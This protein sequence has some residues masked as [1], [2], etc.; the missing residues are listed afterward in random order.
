MKASVEAS[1]AS[2]EASIASMNAS[3]E[4]MEASMEAPPGSFHGIFRESFHGIFR[5]S[6]H[7]SYH[8]S[9]RFHEAST[10]AFTK[11]ST[12]ASTE[13]LPRIR[14]VPRKHFHGFLGFS[15]MEASGSFHGRLEAQR[16][17]RKL[18]RNLFVKAFDVVSTKGWKLHPRNFTVYL[19]GSFRSFHGISA[20]STTAPTDIFALYTTLPSVEPTTCSTTWLTLTLCT[21]RR[22]F[23]RTLV[24]CCVSLG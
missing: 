2:M 23:H 12:K 8:G 14:K 5:E 13:V 19:H 1:T 24:G 7:G 3:M 17:P 4:D 18:P 10:K 9:Y 20:A 6:F 16:L 15:S 22:G 21:R 11:A